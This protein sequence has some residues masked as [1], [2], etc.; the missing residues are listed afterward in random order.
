M[1]RTNVPP[2]YGVPAGPS[3][4]TVNCETIRVKYSQT[5]GWVKMAEQ[6]V[7]RVQ[8]MASHKLLTTDESS[9]RG[10]IKTPGRGSSINL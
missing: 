8:L 3:T 1:S 4:S 7:L 9:A 5:N 10:W 6:L 2:S